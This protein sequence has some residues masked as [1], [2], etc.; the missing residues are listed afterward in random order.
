MITKNEVAPEGLIRENNN[1]TDHIY[2][3]ENL[4]MIR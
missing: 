3:E 1:K 4:V 2:H